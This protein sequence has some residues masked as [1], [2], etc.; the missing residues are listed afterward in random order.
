MPY[1]LGLSSY[2]IFAESAQ[3][4]ISNYGLYFHKVSK[5]QVKTG[6]INVDLLGVN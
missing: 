3:N 4:I 6:R 5:M 1:C 2:K